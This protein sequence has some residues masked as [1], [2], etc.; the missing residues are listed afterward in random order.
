MNLHSYADPE[1]LPSGQPSRIARLLAI[2][3]SEAVDDV[4]LARR[5]SHGLD[6]ASVAALGDVL[7]RSQVIGPIVPEATLR[8][9][10]KAGKRLPREFSERLYE[11]G[12]VVDA[13]SLVYRGD[14]QAIEAFLNKPHPSLHGATP[15][16]LA[17]S[18]SAG[19]DAVLNLMRRIEASVVV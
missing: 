7:G 1:V 16:D 8:R 12:R 5:V 2:P 9:I 17:R 6:P 11:I 18:C 13:V 14:E 19:S 4:Q 3:D 15:F 10:R